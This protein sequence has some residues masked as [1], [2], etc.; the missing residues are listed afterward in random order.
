MVGSEVWAQRAE[1]LQESI[2]RYFGT[3]LRPFR[4]WYPG[5]WGD[6]RTLNYWWHAHAIEA[7][8]DAYERSGSRHRLVQAERIFRYVVWRNGRSLLNDYFDDM[9]WMGIAALRLADLTG[10]GRYQQAAAGLCRHVREHGWNDTAGG[11]IAW[12]KQQPYYKNTPS[13]GTFIIL[14]ARLYQRTGE[15][16]Y[17]D[18]A[19]SAFDWLDAT[20]RRRDGFIADGVNRKQDGQIDDWKFSYNQGLYIGSCTELAAAAG[21]PALTE[22][23]FATER[24]G[25]AEL[26]GSGVLDDGTEGGDVGLFKGVWYRYAA[27]LAVLP[28]ADDDDSERVRAHLLGACDILWARALDGGSLLAGPDWLRPASGRVPLSAQLAAVIATEACARLAG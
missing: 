23:A 4:N 9:G 5:A 24:A 10:S 14:A 18:W 27:Q 15:A 20:L 19:T 3:L 2:D 26:A 11:G 12:R 8:L 13:T 16:E 6:W 1:R 28:G 22:R 17:L 25:W 7:R 21:R